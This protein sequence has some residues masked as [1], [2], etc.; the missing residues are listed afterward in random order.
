MHYVRRTLTRTNLRDI[1]CV[2]DR[3]ADAPL[4]SVARL[5]TVTGMF[6]GSIG[7]IPPVD[8][9]GSVANRDLNTINTRRLVCYLLVLRRNFVTPDVGIRGLSPTTRNFSVIAR[10]HST[11]LRALVD[12]DFNFNN[13]GT[14]LVVGG[15]S[16]WVV[17][18][19]GRGG[20]RRAISALSPTA[21]PD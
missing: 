17:P 2:G 8:S 6:N 12:G 9:A 15:F 7:G 1:S 14:A 4:N 10:G 5:G 20:A 19:G 11:G 3:N 21:R 18:M 16:T 13:A